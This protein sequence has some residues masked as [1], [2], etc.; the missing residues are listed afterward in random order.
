MG[1]SRRSSGVLP[2]LKKVGMTAKR[3]AR[4]SIP[5][6]EKGV[7]AVYGAMSTGL[8]LGMKSAKS[9][10]KHRRGR[11]LAGGRRRSRRHS[12]RRR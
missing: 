2:A 11:S 5:V 4:A 1:K 6:L 12:R 10:V 3:V 8:N 9:L 7:S